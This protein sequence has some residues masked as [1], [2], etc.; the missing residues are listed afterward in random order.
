MK[1]PLQLALAIVALSFTAAQAQYQQPPPQI[2]VSG[3]AEIKVAPDKVCISA[4]VETR[5]AQLDVARRQNDE[6]VASALAFLKNAG[7]PDKDVQTDSIEVQPDYGP[8]DDRTEP[9]FFRVRKSIE[10]KLNTVTNLETVLTGL[11]N[12]GVNNLYDVDFQTTELRKYRDQAR[13]MAIKAAREKAVALC[14]EL[15]V[16]CGKP[17][18]IN[19]QDYGGYYYRPGGAWGWRNNGMFGMNSVQNVMQNNGGGSES[20]GET[21]SLGQINVSATVNVSFLIQ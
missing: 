7:V 17:V 14:S 13:A 9:R 19:A 3:S 10:V 16:K 11:L 1:K 4:G 2:N 15:D 12:N 21:L 5:D 8:G 18:S 6:R 20:P